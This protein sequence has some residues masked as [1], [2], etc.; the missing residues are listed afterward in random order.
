M[1]WA[2]LISLALFFAIEGD[3]IARA[4]YALLAFVG[5]GALYPLV[6]RGSPKGRY[7]EYYRERLGGDGPFQCEV[8][9]TSEGVTVEQNGAQVKWRWSSVKEVA[10]TSGAIEFVWNTGG[11]LVVRDRAFENTEQRAEFLRLS[12]GFAA[13]QIDTEQ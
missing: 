11:S 12:R 3:I 10:D 2:A 8:E 9:I 7:I 1:L 13:R 6:F 4:L 5:L